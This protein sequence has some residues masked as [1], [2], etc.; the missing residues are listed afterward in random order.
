MNWYS[1]D[2]HIFETFMSFLALLVSYHPI[3]KDDDSGLKKTAGQRAMSRQNGDL[4]GQNLHLPAMLTGHV[5]LRRSDCSF[6][7]KQV[8]PNL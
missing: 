1:W 7:N 4:T 8:N 5:M 6:L 3:G 2:F